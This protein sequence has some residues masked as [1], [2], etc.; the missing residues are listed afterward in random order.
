VRA[1]GIAH[2]V[3]APQTQMI[4]QGE[5]VADHGLAV[6]GGIPAISVVVE[7]VDSHSPS[8]TSKTSAAHDDNGQASTIP[9]KIIFFMESSW[10]QLVSKDATW[11]GRATAI[12]LGSTTFGTGDILTITPAEVAHRSASVGHLCVIAI[13]LGKRFRWN[14]EREEVIGDSSATARLG[15]AKRDPWSI[16]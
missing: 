5:D 7:W 8:L 15:R 10:G 3:H 11:D 1:H 9:V 13:G 6:V 12:A 16:V 4:H 2:Q 14:P